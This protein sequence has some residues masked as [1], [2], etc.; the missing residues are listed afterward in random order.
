MDDVE[1][2]ILKIL[3]KHPEGMRFNR[4]YREV[5][6]IKQ[7]QRERFNRKLKS[8]IREGLVQKS[9]L[10]EEPSESEIKKL[11]EEELQKIRKEIRSIRAHG[12]VH[13]YLVDEGARFSFDLFYIQ[14]FAFDL[15]DATEDAWN[16]INSEKWFNLNKESKTLY[17]HY[18]KQLEKAPFLFLEYVYQAAL[19]YEGQETSIL[20]LKRIFDLYTEYFSKWQTELKKVRK[21][22]KEEF[23]KSFKEKEKF[24]VYDMKYKHK[25]FTSEEKMQD[26]LDELDDLCHKLGELYEELYG[27]Q[28]NKNSLS[29]NL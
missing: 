8:L 22:L 15:D 7:C 17:C 16:I 20:L 11:S 12:D 1:R 5:N 14:E 25:Q 24:V 6:K 4:L 9:T 13:Y 19:T 27:E 28:L 18:F 3:S 23:P 29:G 2:I 10:I 26:V 21:K